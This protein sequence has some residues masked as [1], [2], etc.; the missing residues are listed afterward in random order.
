MNENN[1]YIISESNVSEKLARDLYEYFSGTSFRANVTSD[2]T[3][4]VIQFQD[5]YTFKFT[6]TDVYGKF[7]LEIRK[8]QTECDNAFYEEM[9]RTRMPEPDFVEEV[10]ANS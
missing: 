8:I 6:S 7:L 5:P 4:P 3:Y 1:T 2:D 9:E 10:Y